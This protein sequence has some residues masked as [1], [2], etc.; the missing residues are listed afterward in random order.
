VCVNLNI[1]EINEVD[2]LTELMEEKVSL[3]IAHC[4]HSIARLHNECMNSLMLAAS[5]CLR[6]SR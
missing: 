6:S 5:L 1:N 4:S 2:L 3:S